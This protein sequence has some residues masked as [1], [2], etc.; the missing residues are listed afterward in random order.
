MPRPLVGS[1]TAGADMKV[2]ELRKPPDCQSNNVNQSKAEFIL[3]LPNDMEIRVR[4]MD[5]CGL[6][7]AAFAHG[8]RT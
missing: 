1:L 3:Q 7:L 2:L 6:Q 8:G 5:R 4:E